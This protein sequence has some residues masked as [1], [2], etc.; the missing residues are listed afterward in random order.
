MSWQIHI[1]DKSKSLLNENHLDQ[2]FKI[3]QFLDSQEFLEKFQEGE[4]KVQTFTIASTKIHEHYHIVAGR[5][6]P[7]NDIAII[8]L[9]GVAK[10]CKC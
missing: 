9:N 5:T 2:N 4:T 7:V 1:F 3:S 6:T 8:K 10:R